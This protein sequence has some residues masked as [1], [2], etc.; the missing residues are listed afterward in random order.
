MTTMKLKVQ[1]M[2][3]GHC[4]EAV[5]RALEGVD[6]VRRADVDL[7]AGRAVVEY[8]EARASRAA[9]V[10]AVMDEGYTAEESV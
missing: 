3:C 9:L 5:T 7:D 2:S 4:V 6:G 10:G 1:G 8:D